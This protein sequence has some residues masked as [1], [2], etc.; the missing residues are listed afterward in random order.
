MAGCPKSAFDVS[1]TTKQERAIPHDSNSPLT[2][3][4]DVMDRA[5][6]LG[7][8]HGLDVGAGVVAVGIFAAAACLG[9]AF[10]LED[11]KQRAV[12]PTVLGRRR[13]GY[14]RRLE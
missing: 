12:L 10:V 1:V 4:S 9:L 14:R 8:P 5:Y 11:S 7:A 2:Y 13:A 3:A 6:Q